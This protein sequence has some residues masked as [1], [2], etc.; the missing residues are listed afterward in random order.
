MSTALKKQIRLLEIYSMTQGILITF[1]VAWFRFGPQVIQMEVPPS[2]EPMQQYYKFITYGL[3]AF[4]LVAIFAL[5]F[6]KS[7]LRNEML[8]GAG[9][10]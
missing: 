8:M 5:I 9:R 4:I 6:V 2:A 3:L 1:L 10:P 7:K